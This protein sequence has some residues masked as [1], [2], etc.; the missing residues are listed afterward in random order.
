MNCPLCNEIGLYKVNDK[1]YC[2]KHYVEVRSKLIQ[3][4]DNEYLHSDTWEIIC[5]YCGYEYTDSGEMIDSG[6]AECENCNKEFKF[7]REVIVTYSTYK[8]ESDYNE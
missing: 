2:K 8:I 5:P 4:G 3:R 6:I 7:E 1:R